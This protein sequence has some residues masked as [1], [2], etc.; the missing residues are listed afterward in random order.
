MTDEQKECIAI[1]LDNLEA[2]IN[3]DPDDPNLEYFYISRFFK[4]TQAKYITSLEQMHKLILSL[5]LK[6][7]KSEDVFYVK[8]FETNKDII[9][10]HGKREEIINELKT[11]I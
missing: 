10:I 7:V 8:L 4:D 9:Q 5:D 1:I 2:E 3:N 11:K 6:S